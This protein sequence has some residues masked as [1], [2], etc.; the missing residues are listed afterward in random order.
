ME[1]R[2]N[3]KDL[4]VAL[5]LYSI[6][7]M[8]DKREEISNITLRKFPTGT[9]AKQ[10]F[11]NE[12]FSIKEKNEQVILDKLAAYQKKFGDTS[13]IVKNQFYS[14]LIDHFLTK[15][16]LSGI[17]RYEALMTNKINLAGM[18]NNVAWDLTGGDLTSPGKDLAFAEQV[19]KK[20]VDI[21]KNKMSNQITGDNAMDILSAYI[22]YADTYALIMYKQKRYDMAYEVQDEIYRLDTLGM[23][24]DGRE[25]Y[26][27]YMEKVKGPEYTKAF[28][29]QQLQQGHSS[30]VM[31]NQLRDICK[32]LSLPDDEF[33]KIMDYALALANKEAQKEAIEKYGDVKAIDFS[34]TNLEG[35]K[36]ELSGYKG[37]V[38]VLD[39]W[40][41]WCG[42]CLASLPHMQALVD[43]YKDKEV[44]FFFVDTWQEGEPAAIK[45]EVAKFMKD[46]KYSFEVLFDYKNEVVKKYKIDGIPTKIVIDKNGDFL[47]INSS[48]DNLKA[49]IDNH[50]N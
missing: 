14:L 20:S 48:A 2:E 9:L 4:G 40:A 15:K 44:M 32:K 25:R 31:T 34:L 42:P 27:M 46:N 19:S 41:T 6:L 7:K 33:K 12:V 22:G 24:A 35:K 30:V 8:N 5:E 10:L 39:F 38:V 21:L 1:K 28:I 43:E 45:K 29:E 37:K 23:G 17:D 16:D 47:S 50:T 26:A 18:Y 11:M 49:L 3:E 36:F 13:F